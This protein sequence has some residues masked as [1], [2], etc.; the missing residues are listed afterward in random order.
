M[1]RILFLLTLVFVFSTQ[2]F[3]QKGEVVIDYFNNT[4]GTVELGK[5]DILVIKLPETPSTGYSWEVQSYDKNILSEDQQ[6]HFISESEDPI[7]AS[8]TQEIRFMPKKA[9]VSTIK[10]IYHRPWQKSIVYSA[11]YTINSKGAYTGEVK[12]SGPYVAPKLKPSDYEVKS[13][14]SAFTW[15][16]H[17]GTSSVKDQ[18]QCGGCWAFA[19]SAVFEGDIKAKDGVERDLS[20][21][22]LISCNTDGWSCDGG[23]CPFDYFK[24]KIGT[25]DNAAGAVYESEFPYTQSNASCNAPYVHHEKIDSWSYVGNTSTIPSDADIK[26]AIYD[27]GSVWVG[28]YA[29]N[30]FQSYTGGVFQGSSNSQPNHAVVLV[31][32]DDSQQCWIMKNSWSSSWGEDG[33]MRIKYGVNSIGSMAAYLVYSGSGTADTQAPSAPTN[34]ASSNVAST[35]LTLNWTA[36]TDNVGV[37]GYD[38]YKNGS[39]YTTVSSTTANVT[40][41]S[42]NTSYSFYVKAKDAAGNVSSASSTI[43]VTTLQ[44]GTTYCASEGQTVTDEWIGRVQLGSIDN[45]SSNSNGGYS[46]F[47]AQSTTLNRSTSYTITITPTWSGTLYNEGEAVWIDYNHDGDFDDAGEQVASISASETSPVS[48]TFTVPS[49]AL[50][51]ATRMRVSM[52]YNGIPTACET[53]SYGEVE[54]YTVNISGTADTQAPSAPTN[55]ASSNVATT[56]LTLS[57]TASSDNVGVTGYDVY[58]NGTSIGSV[59]STSANVTGLTA[60][61]SYSFYVKAKDA[62]GNVSSASNTINVTTQQQ[63]ISYCASKGN[64][65]NYE[66]IDLVRFGSIDNT[67]GANGGY[68]DFTNLSTN[69]SVGGTQRLYISAGF[70]GSSYTEYWDVWIDYNHNGVFDSNEKV[71][72]GSSSSADELYAD[73]TIPSDATLGSTRMRVSM[74]YGAAATPCETFD[75]GEVEDYTVNITT[76]A[77]FATSF[78][79]A[80]RLGNSKTSPVVIYPNPASSNVSVK[81]NEGVQSS[82]ISILNLQGAVLKTIPKCEKVQNIDISNLNSGCYILKVKN[83]RST[84]SKMLIK[85]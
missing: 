68:A 46:D 54:D 34:L 56:S 23:L 28:V 50:T 62:A 83:E 1:K 55:L 51:G 27:H 4:K 77:Q 70:S 5:S 21:Q 32:W 35:S 42:A 53:F 16:D 24:D 67:T 72:S 65:S 2:M 41:L 66:Y 6:S 10:L 57:W 14:P 40:G 20:E 71:V 81:I 8:G 74:K 45:S 84:F 30:A 44:G 69:V 25:G 58:E 36:S 76:A 80:K 48:A 82:S 18:G 13:L 39:L 26:Q 78:S 64:S 59:T 79:S 12:F 47:T 31:G 63:S 49:S 75:Y 15:Q 22:F 11:S 60:G 33:Y 73:V 38:V 17:N 19:A 52:K 85:K 61:T 9:G 43:N 37:T 29:D 7:G 3:G